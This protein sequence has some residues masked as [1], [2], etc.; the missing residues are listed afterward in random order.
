M[1]AK[2][3]VRSAGHESGVSDMQENLWPATSL[4]ICS[5][6]RPVMLAESVASILSGTRLPTELIIID[7]S[8]TPSVQ[9]AA[10]RTDRACGIRYRWSQTIGLSR[11]NNLGIAL[12]RCDLLAFTHDDVL[13]APDWYETLVTAAVAAGAHSAVTGQVRPTEAQTPG[14]FVP[15]IRVDDTPA[16]YTGRLDRDVLY[17]LNMAMYRSAFAEVGGFDER[18]GPGTIF[19]GA[20]DSDL[21]FRLLEAGYAIHYVPQAV[22][23]HRAW[24]TAADYLPLRW[25][26][27]RARGAMFAKHM[28]WHDGHMQR[29]LLREVARLRHFPDRFRREHR[30]AYGDVVLVSGIL[31]GAAWWLLTQR[32]G[33]LPQTAIGVVERNGEC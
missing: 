20:E 32:G 26:Y 4:I 6:N 22:V 23:Y 18:L 11:A 12:A 9:L 21:G 1:R 31:G 5:R 27:G 17:P 3:H 28:H 7:Q 16:I 19:P 2:R 30:L 25:A 14:G 13:V 24:R 10:L 8:D 33:G 15:T 29:R